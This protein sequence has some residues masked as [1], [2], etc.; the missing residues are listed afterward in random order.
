M[1]NHFVKAIILVK[2]NFKA[3]QRLSS[4]GL[5]HSVKLEVFEAIAVISVFSG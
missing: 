5:F 2:S 3:L 1:I 4:V